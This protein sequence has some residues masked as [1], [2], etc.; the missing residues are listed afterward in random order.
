VPADRQ[1]IG[2]YVLLGSLPWGRTVEHAHARKA[3]S[4]FALRLLRAE[5]GKDPVAVE[6]FVARGRAALRFRHPGLVRATQVG[7]QDG[8]YFIATEY[9]AGQTLAALLDRC[10]RTGQRLSLGHVAAIAHAIASALEQIHPHVRPCHP[11]PGD[12]L[13]GYDGVVRLL[14]SEVPSGV[15][16]FIAPEQVRGQEASEVADQFLLGAMMF[17]M[18]TLESAF[19]AEN[20]FQ[21]LEKVRRA[22]VPPPSLWNDRVPNE[23]DEIVRRA[24]AREPAK[25]F[26]NAGAMAQALGD[27]QKGFM[28]GTVD[29]ADLLRRTF[30]EEV[31]AEE[32]A[33]LAAGQSS[34]DAHA[35]KDRMMRAPRAI[36]L[37]PIYWVG[38]AVMLAGGAWLAAGY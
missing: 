21:S 20:E 4:L 17:E 32:A 31:Q 35:I 33:R 26:P 1:S 15:P 10:R 8:R 36:G 28:F 2:D 37:E 7:R 34:E 5:H 9:V 23:M 24:A 30:P 12:V 25:R 11:H 13:I 22:E 14:V 18:L 3:G 29:L 19:S 6:A 16:A 27:L 38:I